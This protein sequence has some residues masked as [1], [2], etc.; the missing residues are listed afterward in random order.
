M[1]ILILHG[2]TGHSGIHWQ[3]WL[4]DSLV[5]QGHTVFMPDLPGGRYPKR[6]IWL[7]TVEEAVNDLEL[8]NAVIVGHSLGV[9]TALDFIEK[10]PIKIKGLIS[11][12]GFGEDYGAELNSFFMKEKTIDFQKVL[13]HVQRKFVIYGDN[14]N[15]VPQETLLALA[16]HLQ[17]KPI[18]IP[19]GGHLN[20]DAYTTLPLLLDILSKL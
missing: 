13:K 9:V 14:D 7:N 6:S 8:D 15:Y 12:A 20:S 19:H 18:I 17:V 4:H 2:I 11:V 10:T 1:T 5:E 16:T 3:Q